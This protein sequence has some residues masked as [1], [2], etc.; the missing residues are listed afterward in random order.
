MIRS[1][2]QKIA[3]FFFISAWFIVIHALPAF[4][5]ISFDTTYTAQ[6]LVDQFLIGQGIRAGNISYSGPRVGIA[7][8][9]TDSNVL[10][11]Q[12]GIILSTGSVF[13]SNGPNNSPYTTT[14]F[15]DPKSKKR[16]KGDRDLN[17]ICRSVTYDVAILEFDFI[18]FN[19]RISFSYVFGSEE[20][21]EYVGSK[22]NDVF[23]FIVDGEK[24]NNKN[25]AVIPKTLLPVTINNIN[26]KDNEGFYIDNDF[27]KKVELKKNLPNQKKKQK[28]NYTLSD[29]YEINKKKLKKMNQ[30]M[31]QTLQFDGLT[32]ILTAS[33]YV[34][35]FKRYHMK[36]AI[37]DVGDPQYD[38]GVFLEEGSFT[39]KKDPSQTRFKDY[40]DL[41]SSINFDSIFGLKPVISAAKRDSLEKEQA[42]YQR[43]TVTNV[44][45]EFDSYQIPDSS[46][47]E[48]LALATYLKTHNDFKCE[49]YGYTDNRGSKKY[50][51][52]LSESRANNVMSYL[53][54]KGI[55][56]Q[57]ISIAG[58][59]F[60]NPIADN[61]DERGRAL[62]RR[63]EI[64]L[65]EDQE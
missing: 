44:N 20:Y 46:K 34:V 43:F 55:P 65:V 42:E 14:S 31:V 47:D 62:N 11:I 45:F 19:N 60:E 26:F 29:K 38:S 10:G 21:P 50:N 22:Y 9:Q 2:R 8:F 35:P 23:G 17:R 63:V 61:S 36:I 1:S 12:S 51:Q 30:A 37:G 25:L 13:N 28:P 33:A 32:T 5:Q 7:H 6:Q 48:L 24:L 18:P 16:P 27:F 58:Y 64:I 57:K 53:V 15:M 49:L 4:A 41:S 59:N 52:R 3:G 40:P 54:A 56:A 39:S